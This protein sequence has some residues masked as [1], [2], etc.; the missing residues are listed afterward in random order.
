LRQHAQPCCDVRAHGSSR[1]TRRPVTASPA[2]P[3]ERFESGVHEDKLSLNAPPR[4]STDEP[5]TAHSCALPSVLYKPQAFE[6]P[7]WVG[8]S[9]T[10]RTFL[11]PISTRQLTELASALPCAVTA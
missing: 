2:S 6:L 8:S 1:T 9:A 11:P 3:C 5:E 10:P 4:T 7:D